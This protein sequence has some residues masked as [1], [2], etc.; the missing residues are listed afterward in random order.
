M[1]LREQGYVTELLAAEAERVVAH[2]AAAHRN[3][4]LL[5][6]TIEEPGHR[7]IIP[8]ARRRCRKRVCS[9][10]LTQYCA[11][12]QRGDSLARPAD[13]MMTAWNH[14]SVIQSDPNAVRT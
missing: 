3:R 7:C 14:H 6:T 2:H 12:H 9:V 13:R 5:D 4:S 8:V 1:R 11:K 10:A